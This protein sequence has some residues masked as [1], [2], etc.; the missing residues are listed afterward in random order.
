MP[1]HVCQEQAN[2]DRHGEAEQNME[3]VRIALL[4]FLVYDS[5]AC[6]KEHYN[7]FLWVLL[8]DFEDVRLHGL[9]ARNASTGST[10]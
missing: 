9:I 2:H 8:V 7:F 10:L 1:V 4:I 5:V 3:Y 6:M